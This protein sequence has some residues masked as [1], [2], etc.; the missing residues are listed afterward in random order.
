V[1]LQP[2]GG[3]LREIERAE[4]E[5]SACLLFMDAARC[6]ISCSEQAR[7]LVV[8][9][10]GVAPEM[11]RTLAPELHAGWDWASAGK[12]V[13][14]SWNT[15]SESLSACAVIP[16]ANK[17]FVIVLTKEANRHDAPALSP[18]EDEVMQWLLE[19]KTNEEIGIILSISSH[20]VKNHLDRIYK[21]LGVASRHSAC[22]EWTRLKTA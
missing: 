7:A 9:S 8:N 22:L 11:G 17:P 14:N 1:M 16:Q 3:Y 19:G 2:S 20:T 12:T 5:L 21:K 18:R 6:L 10:L 15:P 13:T 4:A